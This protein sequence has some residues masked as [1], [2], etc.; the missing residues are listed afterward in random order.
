ML[1]D[2]LALSS[3]TFV[4]IK[5]GFHRWQLLYLFL[6]PAFTP[7]RLGDAMH[8]AASCHFL[9]RLLFLV[10][11]AFIPVHPPLI[12]Q[13]LRQSHLIFASHHMHPFHRR[14]RRLNANQKRK[15]DQTAGAAARCTS[16]PSF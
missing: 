6:F 16:L 5:L 9:N 8:T 14:E 7:Q 4:C 15:M 10:R 1:K 13:F 3:I 2:L 12:F 11:V